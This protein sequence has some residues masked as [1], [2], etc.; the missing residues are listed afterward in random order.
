MSTPTFAN[1]VSSWNRGRKWE[2]FLDSVAPTPSTTILDVGYQDQEY[3][4]ADNYLEKHYPYQGQITALGVDPPEAFQARYPEVTVVHYPGHEW[5]FEDQSFDVVWS[6]AVLEHVGDHERQLLFLREARRVGKRLF[7]TTPNR[8]FPI[9]I[10]T[11]TPLLHLMMDKPRFDAYL[12]RH[13]KG[14]AAGD[15]MNLLSAHDL[16]ELCAEADIE[17]P[18]IVRN[19]LGGVTL[20]FVVIS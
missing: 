5:P 2:L 20:D 4:E 13:G 17:Q 3:Q 7:I 16:R 14:W 18:R 11:R 12:E 10:H 19:R 8:H 15:Y 1:R 6:N 9:E